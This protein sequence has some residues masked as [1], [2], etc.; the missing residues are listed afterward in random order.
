MTAKKD[1][2]STSENENNFKSFKSIKFDHLKFHEQI[3]FIS[4]NDENHSQKIIKHER[5]RLIKQKKKCLIKK[6]RSN[7]DST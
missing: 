1:V 2:L 5:K 7:N 3:F 6:E 4:E